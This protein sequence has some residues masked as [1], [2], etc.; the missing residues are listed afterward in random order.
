M[1]PGGALA[2]RP[3]VKASLDVLSAWIEGQRAYSGLPGASLGVMS[4]ST[5]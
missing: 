4:T 1:A 3:D 5:R 2:Q